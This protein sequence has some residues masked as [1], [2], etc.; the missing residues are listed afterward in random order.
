MCEITAHFLSGIGI[1]ADML[2]R[3]LEREAHNRAKVAGEIAELLH[4]AC[5]QTRDLARG[6][7]PVDRDEG[8]LESALDELASSTSRLAGISCSFL[9]SE[10]A[11][12]L[13][14]AVAIHLFRI[15]QEALNNA[16]KHGRA[17]AVIIALEATN[18]IISLRVSDDGIGFD[19]IRSSG[20]GMGLN[21]MHYRARMIGGTLEVQPNS[22]S[23]TIIAFFR[24][25]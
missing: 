18:D 17:K 20:R 21:I 12:I 25:K 4:D 16:T 9:C 23:G 19:P 5:A 8:G 11:R 14:N 3:D 13:D 24:R 7:S 10:P 2:K 22:P 15:A 1:T 6:L